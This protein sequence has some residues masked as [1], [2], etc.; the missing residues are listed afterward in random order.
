[1]NLR[2]LGLLMAIVFSVLGG[3]AMSGASKSYVCS[4]F[5]GVLVGAGGTPLKGV[6]VTRNWAWRSKKGEDTVQTDDQG[7]FSFGAVEAKRGFFGRASAEDA[8]TQQFS[9][10]GH[11]SGAPFLILTPR[12]GPL[13]HE[14]KGQPISVTCDMSAEPAHGGFWYGTC[15]LN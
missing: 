9:A 12:V 14:N 8:V 6:S 13:N 5:E 3:T 1:M 4:P 10:Q 2:I 15:T 11:M 7:R